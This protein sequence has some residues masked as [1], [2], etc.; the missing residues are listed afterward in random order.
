[1]S[2]LLKTS[3][4]IDAAVAANS[5]L[6]HSFYQAWEEGRLTREALQLYARQY[7]HHVEAFPQAVSATHALCPSP[8]GRKL[9]AENL[10]EEEGLAAGKDDHAT[11]WMQ[12]A[13]GLGNDEAAVRA[14]T[15]HPETDALID[16]FRTLSRTSYAAGLGALYAYESQL[17]AIADTKIAGLARHYG[18]SDART[19]RFFDVHRD[20]DVEHSA[21][22]RA[23]IDSLPEAERADAEAGALA[24]SKALLGFLDGMER[25]AALN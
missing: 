9:L 5:M 11:L 3:Q 21:A 15:L 12:F 16:A 2:E 7:Y 13:L 4:K 14:E 8:A 25:A 23:L 18:V 6:K 10:A 22:C 24:L 20:A 19:I 1:M 17:P